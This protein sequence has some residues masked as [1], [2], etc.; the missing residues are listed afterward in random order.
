MNI[1]E[2][3]VFPVNKENDKLKAFATITLDNCFV[4][5]DLKV[6]HGQTG[7]FIAMPSRKKKDGSYADV[8]HPL[9]SATRSLIE[10]AVIEEYRTAAN[11]NGVPAEVSLRKI[12]PN[13]SN[14]S[15][16]SRE[17]LELN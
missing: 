15:E 10:E 8:A 13:S 6:I 7:L 5:R 4:I 3:R 11:G 14:F 17:P 9:D 1:T 12:D 2:V 16:M